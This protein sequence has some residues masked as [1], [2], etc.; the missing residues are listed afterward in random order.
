MIFRINTLNDSNFYY[1]DNQLS[2]VY[3]C[4]GNLIDFSLDFNA[5]YCKSTDSGLSDKNLEYF[6]YNAE[7]IIKK[8]NKI[9]NTENINRLEITLGYKCNYRCKYCI[10]HDTHKEIGEPF[11]FNLFVKRFEKSGIFPQIQDM[12]FTGGEPFVYFDRFKQFVSYFR[13]TLGYQG[14]IQIVTNGELFDKEK[15]EFC[16][17]NKLYV[18]FSHDAFAQTYYRHKTDYLDAIEKRNLIIEQLKAGQNSFGISKSGSINFVINPKVYT[19]ELGLDFFNKKLYSGVPVSVI[20]LTKCDSGT[21]F[22]FNEWTQEHLEKATN[23]FVHA[24]LC[25]KSDKYFPYYRRFREVLERVIYRIVNRLPAN[26]LMSRCPIQVN[27][28]ILPI[29]YNGNVIA[30][31]ASIKDS[32]IVDGQI[33]D[34]Q[35]IRFNF[36]SIK[37]YPKCYSCPYVIACGCACP[38]LLNKKDHDIRCKSLTPLI[39][40]E[41][42]AAFSFLLKKQVKEIVPCAP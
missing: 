16:L 2:R 10:Q 34:L 20:L 11:D 19:L 28:K 33:D 31:W 6:Q 24:M 32:N 29:D 42:I 27:S 23:S 7:A 41:V 4:F 8:T 18:Y 40:A 36:K 13:N 15:L 25:D 1:Y 17:K 37:D 3:D 22:I 12:K 26:V 14:R 39:K 30:C 21:E 38:I 5:F 9:F 35:H